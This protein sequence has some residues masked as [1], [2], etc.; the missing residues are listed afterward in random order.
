MVL[1]S[2]QR[3]RLGTSATNPPRRNELLEHQQEITEGEGNSE[4][5]KWMQSTIIQTSNKQN[6][7]ITPQKE[8]GKQGKSPS[9]F[10]QKASSQ[11][12]SSGREKEQEK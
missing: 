10:Y 4:I 3:Q 12:T 9:S 1:H 5:L 7:G 11:P 2:V 8:G 6:K